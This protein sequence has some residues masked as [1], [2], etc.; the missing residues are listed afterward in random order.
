MGHFRPPLSQPMARTPLMNTTADALDPRFRLLLQ[1]A[2]NLLVEVA[3]DSPDLDSA[4]ELLIGRAFRNGQ[5]ILVICP[6]ALRSGLHNRLV[7]LCKLAGGAPLL[8]MVPDEPQY[9][10]PRSY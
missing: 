9:Q 5:M 8:L 6:D 1:S 3:A 2:E 7:A 10:V 4:L